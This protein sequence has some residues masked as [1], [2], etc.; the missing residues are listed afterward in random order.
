MTEE[1]ATNLAAKG[2]TTM[3][4]LAEHSVDELLDIRGMTEE[5]RN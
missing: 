2:I 5:G 4:E 3:E 1:L